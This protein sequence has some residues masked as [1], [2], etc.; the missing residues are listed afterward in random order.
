MSDNTRIVLMVIAT[1]IV[2]TGIASISVEYLKGNTPI[3][4]MVI[5][6]VV[7]VMSMALAGVYV[8]NKA[9]KD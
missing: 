1:I 2:V 9:V 3:I 5:A 6:M 4:L 8:L 7:S